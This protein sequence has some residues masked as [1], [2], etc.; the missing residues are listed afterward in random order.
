MWCSTRGVT[1]LGFDG[2]VIYNKARS[3]IISMFTNVEILKGFVD[4]KRIKRKSLQRL[5]LCIV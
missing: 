5:E 3:L 1:I 2:K 4:I